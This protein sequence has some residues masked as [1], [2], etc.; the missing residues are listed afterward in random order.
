M[1]LLCYNVRKGC[2][3][4]TLHL[5]DPQQRS[6][7]AAFPKFDP[8]N[9]TNDALRRNLVISA[10][11]LLTPKPVTF[12][13]RHI[14]G[15]DGAPEVRVIMFKPAGATGKLPAIIYAHGGGMIAGTPDMMAGKHAR[16]ADEIGA[17]IVSV[18]Y[19]L[20]PETPFPG[21]LEDIYAALAWL[22]AHAD[23]LG[24][25]PDRISVMGNSGGGN[26]AAA[27]ALLARDRN[28]VPVKAQ[29]LI[30]PMLDLRT[31]T[32]DAVSNDPLTGEFVWT[33]AHNCHAWKAVRNELAMNDPRMGYLSPSLATDLS[34][35]PPALILV[36]ALDLFRDEDIA[37]AQRLWRAGVPADLLVYAGAVH[38]FDQ[39]PSV[40]AD[41]AERDM[42]EG[43]LRII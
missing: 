41:R 9:D 8:A 30:Y 17:L 25:D 36:G 40:L 21:G 28:I 32:P 5:V 4:S 34:R 12:D 10:T 3:V 27:V 26:L 37:Y 11:A 16:N 42:I 38:A 35:L 2:I 22:H 33:R 1:I 29:I 18:D 39:L 15:P 7:A 20:A 31:G 23:E 43:I 14:P 24:V 19:R 6:A 13:E